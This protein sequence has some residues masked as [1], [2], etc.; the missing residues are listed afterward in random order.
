MHPT[1][2]TPIDRPGTES[3]CLEAIPE[4]VRHRLETLFP[5]AT[6]WQWCYDTEDNY[7]EVDCLVQGRETNVQIAADGTLLRA[8]ES[9]ELTSLPHAVTVKLSEHYADADLL[10]VGRITNEDGEWWG[11]SLRTTDGD[12][13]MVYCR[14]DGSDMY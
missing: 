2:P 13:E 11:V 9:R 8:R 12:E 3:L 14:S 10:T 6:S 5:Y 4:C 1:V 7:F